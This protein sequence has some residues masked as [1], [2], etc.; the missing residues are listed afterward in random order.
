MNQ[1]TTIAA[2]TSGKC[3]C[4]GKKTTAPK[5]C[6]VTVGDDKIK[7]PDLAIYSQEEQFAMGNSPTWNSPD[8]V[9]NFT[10]PMKLTPEASIKVSNLSG[11]S[12]SNA[13]VHIYTSPFGI[14]TIETL[15]LTQKVNIGSGV[16]VELFYPWSQQILAGD[17]RIGIHILIE[18][19][20]DEKRINNR[21]SQVIDA[22]QTSV[23]GRSFHVPVPVMN[24]N[25]FS[26]QISLSLLTTDIIAT[27]S[28]SG[29]LFAP[30]EQINAN[31]HLTIPGFLHGTPSENIYREVTV[32]ARLS[33]GTVIGGLT[34]ILYIDN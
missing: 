13:L 22:Y 28:P 33:N 5:G 14:G 21:G 34:V 23:A 26:Q 11:V 1:S 4:S 15:Q 20:Y 24:N 19:P 18:H 7:K 31:L 25:A 6:C 8:I 12:A 32:V 2:R 29:H 30:F 16:Q 27:I 17:P 10:K 3:S 9:T